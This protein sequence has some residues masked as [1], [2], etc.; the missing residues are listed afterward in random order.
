MIDALKSFAASKK[1]SVAT[2]S[3]IELFENDGDKFAKFFLISDEENLKKWQVTPESIPRRIDTFKGMPFVSEPEL[4]HFGADDMPLEEILRVQETFR[5]GTI[6]DTQYNPNNHQ[7]FAIVKFENNKLGIE[8]WEALQRGE[9]V[10][11]SPAVAGSGVTTAMGVNLFLDWVGVHLARVKSPAYGVFH[12]SIKSTCE[13][14]EKACVRNLLASASTFISSNDSFN[15]G[16]VTMSNMQANATTVDDETKVPST[17]TVAENEK[18][19]TELASVKSEIDTLKTA[20][21]KIG[22]TNNPDTTPVPDPSLNAGQ[23]TPVTDPIVD[24]QNQ[25]VGSATESEDMKEVKAK[26]ASYERKAVASLSEEIV[27]KKAS[28]GMYATAAEGEADKKKLESASEE[29]LETELASIM[30]Y[31]TKIAS[32]ASSQGQLSNSPNRVISQVASASTGK[33]KVSSLSDLRKLGVD[34]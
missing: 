21:E 33:T 31:I 20:F 24:K 7:A 8:T 5:A 23:T 10:Y 27:E 1:L 4:A 14:D 26:L 28:A 3:L 11:V 19:K 15:I 16:G 18:L 12:A 32:M 22:G 30:P 17:A 29:E 34:V 2:A 13:G 6:I 9:A 25:S